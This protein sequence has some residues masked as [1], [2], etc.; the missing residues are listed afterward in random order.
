[1]A[2]LK[3]QLAVHEKALT[4]FPRRAQTSA[5]RREVLTGYA[6]AAPK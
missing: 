3:L 1:M 5:V 4:Q 6:E 2:N